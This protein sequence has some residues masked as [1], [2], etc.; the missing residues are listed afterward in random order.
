MKLKYLV[1]E[2]VDGKADM[3]CAYQFDT[4]LEAI[5]FVEKLDASTYDIFVKYVRG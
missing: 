5:E 2:I 4:E 3:S 1:C